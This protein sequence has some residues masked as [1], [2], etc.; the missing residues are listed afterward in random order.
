MADSDLGNKKEREDELGL[1]MLGS[2]LAAAFAENGHPSTVWNRT[3]GKTVPTSREVVH[4]AT[5]LEAVAAAPVVVV[6][7][8]DYATGAGV[9]YL[10]GSAMAV[11]E[12]IGG[13]EAVLL[14]SGSRAAFEASA[15]TLDRLG[16]ST[17]LGEDPAA[18]ALFD[19][20]LLSA[21]Y[22]MYAGFFHAAAL[23]GTEGIEAS[24]LT[25]LLVPWLE[26]TS[27]LLPGFARQID[28]AT[29]PND[30]SSVTVNRDALAGI[31]ELS[32]TQGVRGDLLHALLAV[33]E[34]RDRTG[35]GDDGFA[36]L[37][38]VVQPR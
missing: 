36:S 17:Y 34:Q 2:R 14:Y 19:A 12:T 35:H 7:V 26:A 30:V 3:P 6:C 20:G 37:I 23:V 32:A 10:D 16:T 18:A 13:P 8:S 4:V 9:G 31:V 33:A 1:G 11:P 38:E 27:G 15:R 25:S 21:M 22:G 5:A 28:E 24:R 29:Y